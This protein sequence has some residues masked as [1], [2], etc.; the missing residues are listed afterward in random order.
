MQFKENI[1]EGLKAIKDNL[2]R[3]VLTASIV[4][5]GIMALVGILTAIDAIQY[6]ISSGLAGLGGNSFEITS[7]SRSRTRGGVKIQSKGPIEFKE[8]ADFKQKF[9]HASN[10]SINTTVTGGVEV[11]RFSKKSNPNSTVMGVD[12]YF[13]TNKGY[14]LEKGRN[15]SSIEL[16]HGDNVAIIGQNLV[17]QIFKDGEPPLNKEIGF[18]G[19][20]YRVVG[21]LEKT[22]GLGG[23]AADRSILIPLENA[24]KYRANRDLSYTI[25]VYQKDPTRIEYSMGE[26]TGLMR[27]IRKDELGKPESFEINRS[28]SIATSLNDT[29]VILKLGGATIGMVTLLGAAIGLMNIMMVSVT[30][31]TREIGVRKALGA[32]PKRIREQF[33]FEAIIIC[34]LGG[35]LGIILGMSIGNLVAKLLAQGEFIVPWVWIFVGIVVCVLVGISAGY[36]PARKASKLDPIESLRYE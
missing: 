4:A 24:N 36:Y 6:T 10:V 2:L 11:K 31:R 27:L 17:E 12:E 20:K 25:V 30:E 18:L 13:I 3:S 29:S 28:E 14:D 1:N 23:G 5:L 7:I 16:L 32:T 19:K 9:R 21:I 22:G 34:L 26:A 33:L 15:F 35:A 8:A